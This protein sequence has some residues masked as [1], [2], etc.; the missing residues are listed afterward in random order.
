MPVDSDCLKSSITA[1]LADNSQWMG[2]WLL[3]S[4][5]I[6]KGQI[7]HI[8]ICNLPFIYLYTLCK[9]P[10]IPQTSPPARLTALR[11]IRI[12][13]IPSPQHSFHNRKITF[14]LHKAGS[15]KDKEQGC[16]KHDLMLD[17]PFFLYDCKA[18]QIQGN[19][20]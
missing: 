13:K 6:N 12:Y 20:K 15:K 9:N 8:N 4:L 10:S 1:G 17:L 16:S 5:E 2:F 14:Y 18:K 11:T 3:R 19:K 7:V